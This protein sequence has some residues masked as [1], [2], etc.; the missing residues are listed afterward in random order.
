MP[1][2]LPG[3][4]L[5]FDI[6]GTLLTTAGAGMRAMHSVSRQMF[7]EHFTFSGVEIAG[8]LDPLIFAQA[9]AHNSL[10][11]TQ[12]LHDAFKQRYLE[13]LRREI[14]ASGPAVRPMP[15]VKQLL[16]TLDR[17]RLNHTPLTLGLLTGN[18][19]DAVPIKLRAAGI[20]PSLFQITAFGDEAACRADLVALAR[21]KHHQLTQVEINPDRVVVI[22]DTPHD[23]AC[24]KAHGCRSFAV[25]TGPF[26]LDEL[27]RAGAD[28]VVPNLS[29]PTPLLD[30]LD[31]LLQPS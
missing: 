11:H 12:E 26:K 27:R 28:L 7:G 22:G 21:I 29:D 20:D 14:L 16:E 4:L 24:A 3:P 8:H 25:A 5:L 17:R 18:Y 1:T 30:L 31:Q 10:D 13:Q 6:D 9:L 15:G 23:I 19:S 2:P